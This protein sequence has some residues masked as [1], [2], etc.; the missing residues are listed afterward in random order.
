MST[1]HR[2]CRQ[3][4]TRP[5]ILLFDEFKILLCDSTQGACPIVGDIFKACTWRDATVRVSCCGVVDPITY[6]AI[7]LLF[8]SFLFLS[9]IHTLYRVCLVPSGPPATHCCLRHEQLG[10]VSS[11]DTAKVRQVSLMTNRQRL[12]GYRAKLSRAL[13]YRVTPIT[14]SLLRCL[15]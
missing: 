4:A 13:T 8:H 9:I 12:Y 11:F 10:C 15:R 6:C 7:I 1:P 2:T 3:Q 14:P 5:L